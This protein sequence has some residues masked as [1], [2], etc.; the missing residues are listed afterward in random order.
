[1]RHQQR[2]ASSGTYCLFQKQFQYQYAFKFCVYNI[3]INFPLIYFF[4]KSY[5]DSLSLLRGNSK[6]KLKDYIP[7]TFYP[8]KWDLCIGRIICPHYPNCLLEIH[9]STHATILNPQGSTGKAPMQ[10]GSNSSPWFHLSLLSHDRTFNTILLNKKKGEKGKIS[11]E[12]KRMKTMQF[13]NHG[14]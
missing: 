13:K 7:L 8:R 11:A 6:Q 12:Q 10:V 2:K 3:G 1:M 4:Q 14:F 5:K 9:L